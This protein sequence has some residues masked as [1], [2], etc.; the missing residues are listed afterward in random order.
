[1]GLNEYRQKRDFKKTAEP[2][3]KVRGG[4]PKAK[5]PWFF[6]Q[7][8]AATRLHYDF[9]LQMEGVLKSWA[10][11]KGFPLKNGERHLAVHVEDHP[12]E[13]AQFE[14]SIAPG[15]YGAG[16]VMVWDHGRYVLHGGDPVRALKEGKLHLT[17]SGK[18]LKGDW[19]LVRIKRPRED[20]DDQW[21]LLKTGGDAA[22][23]SARSEDRSVLTN[24]TLER[25][26]SD[27]DTQ[28]QSDRP[29]STARGAKPSR[30]AKSRTRLTD[31]VQTLRRA[32]PEFVEP[33][34]ALLVDTL[35]KGSE[36]VYELKFDG[37]RALAIKRGD[38]ISLVSRNGNSLT[39]RY[40]EVIE[41]LKRLPCENA[42]LDGEIVAVDAEGRSSF[43]LLQ[44]YL[45]PG[46]PK[47]PLL[48][49]VFDLL[50]LEGK[51]VME[52]P[53]T[54]RKE[55]LETLLDGVA[56]ILRFSSRIE[57]E[58]TRLLKEMKKR[59]L[60]GLVA[61]RAQSKYEPGRRSGAWVKFKWSNEQEFVIGGFTPPKGS[62][63]HFGAILTGYYEGGKL[64]FASKVG[65]GFDTQTLRSLHERFKMHIRPD[66]PFANLPEKLPGGLTASVMK[67]CTWLEPELVCQVRFTEWTRDHHLRHPLFLGLRED[68]SAR[69]VVREKPA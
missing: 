46:Q 37:Y 59:G 24:R 69:E 18:K 2:A 67:T 3:G 26:A 35:P 39:G 17:L 29:A 62:R 54:K 64:L 1:M 57:G 63:S 31:S 68:K 52:L 44:S 20:G 5:A 30:A 55:L 47:P 6:V 19:T 11:P 41:A 27:N 42:V 50:N 66:C 7:K 48:Y 28:W 36:W 58:G 14:G 51:S 34:K 4:D 8:H 53:L 45:T 9:R 65:A 21:L 40:P 16:T 32:T 43:Q 22:N 13:Y 49:Y 12:L 33:M 38:T 56:D 10:V 60:E 25:I 23:I 15:N 61:K